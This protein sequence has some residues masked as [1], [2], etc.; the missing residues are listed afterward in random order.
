MTK[1]SSLRRIIRWAFLNRRTGGITVAQWPNVALWSFAALSV[2]VQVNTERGT[3]QPVLQ[4]ASR[5]A[6]VVWAVDELVRG[7]NP[8]RRTLG[9]VVLL[10]SIVNGTHSAP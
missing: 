5:L 3:A 10:A 8:F 7:A 4:F 9:L 2:V 1:S 6:F